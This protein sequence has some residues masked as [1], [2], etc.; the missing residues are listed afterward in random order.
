M[1][2]SENRLQSWKMTLQKKK[3]VSILINKIWDK[4]TSVVNNKF[5]LSKTYYLKRTEH[6]ARITHWCDNCCQYINPGEMYE[7]I[8]QAKNWR[9]TEFKSHFDC[10]PPED[11]T[12]DD[13]KDISQPYRKA[14]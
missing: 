6:I 5:K 12:F 9:I 4:F 11:P 1:E 2:I 10:E 13:E 7:R 8:V 3:V 14:A